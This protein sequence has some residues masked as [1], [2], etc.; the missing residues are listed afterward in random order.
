MVFMNGTPSLHINMSLIEP[1]VPMTGCSQNIAQIFGTNTS[2]LRASDSQA[3]D[4]GAMMDP[5]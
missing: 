3:K 5:N 1:V 2:A 4:Y